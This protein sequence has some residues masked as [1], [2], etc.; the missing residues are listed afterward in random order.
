MKDKNKLTP[1]YV[2][3]LRR[4]IISNQDTFF[5]KGNE[6]DAWGDFC[7]FPSM[8]TDRLHLVLPNE[9]ML[10][11]RKHKGTHTYCIC[12]ISEK[13]KITSEIPVIEIDQLQH[14]KWRNGYF[15]LP[16]LN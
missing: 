4:Y 5:L 12:T 10:I 1:E 14:D 16:Y 6:A 13:R 7:I 2:E 11:D 3:K 9:P 8:K 15:L